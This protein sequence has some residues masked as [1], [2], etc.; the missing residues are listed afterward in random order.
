MSR[1]GSASASDDHVHGD[2]MLTIKDKLGEMSLGDSETLCADL[3][4]MAKATVRSVDQLTQVVNLIVDAAL[5][6]PAFGMLYANLCSQLNDSLPSIK[7]VSLDESGQPMMHNGAQV[8]TDVT[9]KK[10]LLNKCQSEFEDLAVNAQPS[11]SVSA[12]EAELIR[13]KAKAR[14]LG[15]IKFIGELF[16]CGMISPK[17]IH[18]NCIQ[19]LLTDVAERTDE[20]I[21]AL[22]ELLF[23][24]GELLDSDVRAKKFMDSYFEL[25]SDRICSAADCKLSPNVRAMVRDVCDLRASEWRTT[26][27]A[28][29]NASAADDTD[30]GA[31]QAST[32]TADVI[33]VDAIDHRQLHEAPAWAGAAVDF[34]T[35][36]LANAPS[37]QKYWKTI[38]GV[39]VKVLASAL[40]ISKDEVS[41]ALLAGSVG[42]I[43]G[44]GA[45]WT[46]PKYANTVSHAPVPAGVAE[47]Q[48]AK[49]AR[50][51]AKAA[52]MAAK[53]AF[54]AGTPAGSMMQR[55]KLVA[56]DRGDGG[57]A[58][59]DASFVG[60]EDSG[61]SSAEDERSGDDGYGANDSDGGD[62]GDAPQPRAAEVAAS[63]QFALSVAPAGAAAPAFVQHAGVGAGSSAGVNP[64]NGTGMVPVPALAVPD[65]LLCPLGRVPMVN[66]V[67]AADGVTYEKQVCILNVSSVNICWP[68]SFS[69]HESLFRHV[70]FGI[71]PCRHVF[72]VHPSSTLSSGSRRSTTR[73]TRS[74]HCCTIY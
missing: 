5:A 42:L 23:S 15:T 69:G 24:V 11:E 1:E 66:A 63:S 72:S 12:E 65:V 48:A 18:I 16:K 27:K 53:R 3:I 10:L 68:H 73:R 28:L 8:E 71:S 52:D 50:K 43:P 25:M 13:S 54:W 29:A 37:S 35:T 39:S 67:T 21:V 44:I 61:G 56:A 74:S 17:I 70:L 47:A 46:L 4:R 2:A 40:G 38:G 59:G 51:E 57:G 26:D 34:V 31:A 22:C 55:A 33:D 9:F 49:R 45:G 41:A 30:G 20:E 60:S 36:E 64:M 14:K 7:H 62:D 19:Y 58:S 6:E 32:D